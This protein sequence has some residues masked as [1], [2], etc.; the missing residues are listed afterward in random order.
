MAYEK[1]KK[2]LALG[3]G[4]ANSF[5]SSVAYRMASGLMEKFDVYPF[6]DG[7][8][9]MEARKR[10]EQEELHELIRNKVGGLFRKR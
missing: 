3:R 2:L 10:R 4:N 5:E 9:T 7:F 1:I 8:E 6:K